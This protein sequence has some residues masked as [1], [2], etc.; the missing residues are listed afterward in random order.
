[1][2]VVFSAVE[3]DNKEIFIKICKLTPVP[4]MPQLWQALRQYFVANIFTKEF[5]DQRSSRR[6]PK[7]NT[8][9]SCEGNF[10]PLTL[11]KSVRSVEFM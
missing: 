1:M 11:F 8:L 7:I 3:P 2:Q 10:W 5:D 9:A 6:T 4:E